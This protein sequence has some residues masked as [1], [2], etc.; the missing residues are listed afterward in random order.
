ESAA[1]TQERTRL[2][3]VHDVVPGLNPDF[4]DRHDLRAHTD[5]VDKKIQPAELL[6]DTFE[7]PFH[8]LRPR[9]IA[10]DRQ[11]ATTAQP[12]G[13]LRS[14]F[15]PPQRS[16]GKDRIPAIAYQRGGNALANP[17]ARTGHESELCCGHENL[18]HVSPTLICRWEA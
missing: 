9:N 2:I 13:R 7:Q 6:T 1:R 10:R 11:R 14:L 15:E 12:I 18:L 3:H 5:T 4:D 16:A 8:L 17:C